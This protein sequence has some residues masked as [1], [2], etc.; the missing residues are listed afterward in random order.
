MKK[1]IK[2]IKTKSLDGFH[3]FIS[4]IKYLWHV[5][6]LFFKEKGKLRK[7]KKLFINIHKFMKRKHIYSMLLFILIY[8]IIDI[9]TR[10]F[11]KDI[12]FYKL[13]EV[14]PR[15]FSIGYII[16]FLGIVYSLK[17]K[18][19]MIANYIIFIIFIILFLVNNV[20]F[21]ATKNFFSFSMLELASEGSSYMFDVIKNCNILVYVVFIVL[22][23]LFV[24]LVTLAS[25]P[26][27]FSKIWSTSFLSNIFPFL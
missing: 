8:V 9:A 1:Q 27:Q 16:L 5:I 14:V 15:F 24:I 19:A 22:I 6:I 25:F 20:Y 4:K 17:R 23:V 18:Y 26:L 13:W 11:S 10:L 7:I 12:T 21:D 3:L 2:K